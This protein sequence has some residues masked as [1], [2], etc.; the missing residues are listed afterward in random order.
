[1]PSSL[2]RCSRRGRAS[3]TKSHKGRHSACRQVTGSNSLEDFS[4]DANPDF[5]F[6]SES[7]FY[8]QLDPTLQMPYTTAD[9]RVTMLFSQRRLAS[10]LVSL[11]QITATSWKTTLP[12]CSQLP[13][14]VDWQVALDRI[15]IIGSGAEDVVPAEL[16]CILNGAL[17]C[18]VS[19]WKD[20]GNAN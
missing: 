20:G 18:L 1:M 16:G 19:S 14:S 4:Y 3:T 8:A 17:V 15:I 13:Y 7:Q 11:K 9:H 5:G 2:R 10:C 12:L 6:E